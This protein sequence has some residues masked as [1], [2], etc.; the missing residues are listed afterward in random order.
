[1]NPVKKE[2]DPADII[3]INARLFRVSEFYIDKI[4]SNIKYSYE[5]K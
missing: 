2:R 5:R 1:M 3:E 4:V